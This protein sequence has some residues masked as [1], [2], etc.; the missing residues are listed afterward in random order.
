MR[1]WNDLPANAQTVA[2]VE[3]CID[4]L[5]KH[6]PYPPNMKIDREAFAA[7]RMGYAA[8][9]YKMESFMA[10]LTEEIE[11]EAVENG[12][13]GAIKLTGKHTLHSRGANW[14]HFRIDPRSALESF[15]VTYC[16]DGSVCLTGDM[17]CLVWQRE[18]FPKK[19]DY[20][21]PYTGTGIGYFAEKIVRAEESQ[22][23]RSWS[24]DAAIADIKEAIHED[25]DE[26]DR[27]VLSHVYGLL[28]GFES[29]EYGYFQMLEAFND[30]P[31]T[32][33]GEEYCEY[34]QDY[35]EPFKLRFGLLK[36]VSDLII[37]SVSGATD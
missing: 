23:I 26:K 11:P 31:H 2:V 10:M 36:S 30:V 15:S 6:Q 8:A 33:E 22:V 27:E 9:I 18:Y 13:S 32:I 29:G 17:G 3:S 35:S 21:F 5:H 34:G 28:S 37:A 19:P 14:F 24:K 25:R 12:G 1:D 20:G 7:G 4:Y 16:H